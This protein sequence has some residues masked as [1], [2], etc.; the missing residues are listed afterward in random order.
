MRKTVK[1]YYQQPYLRSALARVVEVAHGK[2][3]ELNRTIA[4]PEDKERLS[5]VLT[6]PSIVTGHYMQEQA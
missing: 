6:S 4:Y 1:I 3:I 2:A 5:C